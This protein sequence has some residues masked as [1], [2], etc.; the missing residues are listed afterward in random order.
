MLQ[1]PKWGSPDEVGSIAKL[2]QEL[3]TDRQGDEQR[4]E[5]DFLH[6]AKGWDKETF[7]TEEH[8]RLS[9]CC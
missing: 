2:G 6:C 7:G 8:G 1:L 9:A 3:M 5:S 4:L